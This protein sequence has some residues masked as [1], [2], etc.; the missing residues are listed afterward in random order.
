M[1]T[2]LF[3]VVVNV[4]SVPFSEAFISSIPPDFIVLNSQG[5]VNDTA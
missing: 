2:L 1:E 5:C 4:G 3:A